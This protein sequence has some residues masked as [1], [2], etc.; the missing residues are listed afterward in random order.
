MYCLS[1]NS[2]KQ[3][4]V[5]SSSWFGRQQEVFYVNYLDFLSGLRRL[6]SFSCDV[7]NLP[8]KKKLPH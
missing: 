6:P 7:L 1:E 2:T 8:E 3:E 4:A 5:L